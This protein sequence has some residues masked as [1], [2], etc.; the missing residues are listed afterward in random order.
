V[1]PPTLWKTGK[2]ATVVAVKAN[3]ASA[4]SFDFI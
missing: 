4:M 3:N 2:K 1:I